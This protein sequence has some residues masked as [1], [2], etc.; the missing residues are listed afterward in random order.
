MSVWGRGSAIVLATWLRGLF[1]VVAVVAAVLGCGGSAS[2]STGHEFLASVSEAP[3]GTSLVEPVTVAVDNASDRVFVG[4]SLAGSVDVYDSAG[5][6]VGQLGDGAL[7]PVGVAV[8]EASGDVYVANA[9]AGVGVT[10][11]EPDGEDGYRPLKAWSG[12]GMPSGAFGEVTGVAVDDSKGP[13]AGDV[14]VVE[15]KAVGIEAGAVDVFKPAPNPA[16]DEAGEEG[17]FLKRLA[18]PGLLAP[19]GVAVSSA[20]GR[21]AVADNVLNAV[22][23]Y[24][25]EG[26]FEGKLTGKG[27]PY[28]A[29]GKEDGSD[30]VAGVAAD[31]AGGVLVAEAGRHAVSQYGPAGEWEGWITSTLAGDL[32]EPR[33]VAVNASGEVFVA[34]AGHAVVDR[35]GAGVTVASVATGKVAKSALTRTTALLPGTVN[36]EGKPAEYRFQYG[37]TTALG[38]ETASHASGGGAEAVSALAEGLHAGRTY[39]YRIVAE[40]EDGANYGAIRELQTP[41]AVEAVLTGAVKGLAPE[42]VTLTGSLKRGGLQTHYYFQ[43]GTSEAYGKQSPEP[44]AEVAAAASEKE[45]KQ[46]RTLE[47]TVGGLQPNTRYH[48]RLVAENQEGLSYG[49]DATFTTSGPPRINY[50]PAS[51][52]G[53]EEATINAKI[54]PDELATRYRF[55][56]GETSAYGMEAPLGGESVGAGGAPVAVSAT[57]FGL[58]LGK[59][60]HFR[61][62]AENEAGI[63]IGDDQ[64]FTT[65]PPAPVDAAYV[66]GVGSRVATLHTLIN[67]LGHDTRFYFQYGTERCAANPGACIDAPESPGQD[68]GAGSEDVAG[69]V[70]LSGLTPGTTYYYRVLGSNSLGLTKGAE[71]TFTT[72]REGGSS[73]LPDHRAW[74]MVTPPDKGGAPVEALTREGGLILASE[75]GSSLAYV[76]DGALGEEIQGNRSP[77]MQEVIATRSP[78][79]WVSRDIAT[80]SSKAKGVAPGNPSEYQFFSPDLATALVDPFG[81]A[82]EPPLVPGVTQATLYLRD[83]ATGTFAPLVSEANTAPGT[84]FNG[85]VGFVT[86]TADLSHAVLSSAIALTGPG[87]SRG[88]YEWSG[89]QLHFVSRLPDGK[90]AS[91]AELGFYGR[92]LSRA[93]SA[94]GS[95]MIWT[96]KA[97]NT[98]GGHLYLSDTTRGETLQLDAAQGVAEPE[99][100]SAQFQSASADGSRVFFTDKQKLT[101]DSTAEPGSGTGK[102]DLYECEIVEVA[103]KLTCSLSD[104]TVDSNEG[105]HAAVQ[106]F[107]FGTGEDGSSVYFVAQ[108]VL[109]ENE[110]GNGE[111]AQPGQDNLYLLHY[112]GSRWSRIFIA[113]LSSEDSPEWEGGTTKT[114]TAFSTTRVSPNGRYLAFMSAAPITG[115]DNIDASPAAKGARDEEVYLYDEASASLRCVSC[116]PSGARPGGILDTDESGEGL[117]LLA[118]RRKVWAEFGH[119]HWLAGNIP[120]W[121]AQSLVGAVFQPRYLSDEGRLY[122]NSPDDLVPAAENHKEDVYQYEPSGV[123]SC[124]SPSGGCVSLISG[125]TSTRESAFMETTPDGSNVFF[126]TEAR[127]LPQDT[128]NAADVYDARECTASSPCLSPPAPAPP[129]CSETETCRPAAPAQAIPGGPGGSATFTGPGNVARGASPTPKQGVEAKRIVRPLT[130]AQ[131]LHLALRACRKRYA[132]ARTRRAVCERNARKQYDIKNR[133]RRKAKGRA[134]RAHESSGT[135]SRAGRGR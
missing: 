14:Y 111:T 122:F 49:E 97:E 81:K 45:E 69:E 21:V 132:H 95:R 85:E 90:P 118:D 135:S 47:A 115:Y 105:E 48:Y 80:P 38:S 11:Y 51:A 74:E 33:G 8:D 94:D 114:D 79:G 57:L 20:T 108:G 101:P 52:L 96:V 27:S 17:K 68:I 63:A 127:L 9:E 13:S 30:D 32:G 121:T 107:V 34:D 125:G 12:E 43:Y 106:N 77:E 123:G 128:D 84:R 126:I 113:T 53:H 99:N 117:G 75:Q 66:T 6:Y 36:G 98:G 116:N 64:T 110:N 35:F 59:T 93:I 22:Y 15:A 129:G 23:A 83:D 71:Q 120:G 39:F 18:G 44:P 10:V 103:G 28:G 58:E 78:S 86:A 54:D 65:V 87:S 3:L 29:F 119:E 37:E 46:A 131:K 134:Q 88:L 25:P 5:E 24:G 92:V 130:R 89:G 7:S 50:Q 124:E 1:G 76:V 61:V 31:G 60:Y 70:K 104:L 55:E 109:A 73:P 72:L 133:G 2:A 41:P 26:T 67:P 100:A 82:A 4:D 102:P 40:D 16:G 19:N 56:Y 91:A 42:S 112:D 62:I